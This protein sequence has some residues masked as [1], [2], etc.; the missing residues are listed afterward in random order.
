MRNDLGLWVE[1]DLAKVRSNV[2]NLKALLN[3]QTRLLAVVKANGYGH[4]D[5]AVAAAAID[6]GAEWLGVARVDE[7]ASLRRSGIT[8]PILLLAEPPIGLVKRAVELELTPTIYTP[9]IAQEFSNSR[10]YREITVHIKVDTGMHRYGVDPAEID[11]VLERVHS[12]DGLRVG[13]LWS[14]FAVAD[15]A[16]D[17]F[18]E[19]QLERFLHISE[20]AKLPAQT[21]LHMGNSAAAISFPKAHFDMVRTGIAIYGIYP[22][23]QLTDKV[24]LEPVM[25]LKSRVG[26]VKRHLKGESLSYGQRYTLG[27]DANVATIPC[28]YADGLSRALS[29]RGEVLVRGRRYRICGTITMDHFLIDVR[30]DQVEIGDEVV[31]IGRQGDEQITAYELAE[32]LDTIP[33]E[34]VCGVNS[35]V[36][37]IYLN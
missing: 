35:R 31:I 34:I 37:R 20:S 5:A 25:E 26:L 30:D 29:N 28:G 4:G 21:L 8:H 32:R 7:G 11:L 14:H 9:A 27:Q 22:S 19:V 2:A 24:S 17:P 33:Y 13:G 6:G 3:P 15:D 36:P 18:T 1:V 23:S 16:L 10:S 12:L